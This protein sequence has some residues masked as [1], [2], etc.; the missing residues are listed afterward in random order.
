MSVQSPAR[1]T[2]I[3]PIFRQSASAARSLIPLLL[4]LVLIAGFAL[5]PEWFA[6]P[7]AFLNDHIARPVSWVSNAPLQAWDWLEEQFRS[8]AELIEQK[9]A[10]EHENLILQRKVLQMANLIAEN[11]RLKELLNATEMVEDSVVVAELLSLSP[12]PRRLEITL[13]R[14]SADGT[15]I[16]QPVLDDAGLVGHVIET[17]HHTARVLT[18]ADSNNAVPVQVARSGVRGIAEGSGRLDEIHIRNLVPTTD[19]LA[20]DIIVSSGLGGRYPA[21][22]PVGVVD[23]IDYDGSDAF[24][25]VVVRPSAKLNQSKLFL[26]LFREEA[27]PLA[28][29]LTAPAP[30][31][32]DPAIPASEPPTTD[33]SPP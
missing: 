8:R 25:R 13:N 10:L 5:R 32:N 26:L 17:S 12:D 11:S 14:G 31:D 33:E 2:A 4:A 6:V 19:I 9:Q 1:N 16:G 28:E 24:L 7:R 29:T 3:K 22:Y 21:G 23:S 15:F 20:G 30:G 18:I 27:N